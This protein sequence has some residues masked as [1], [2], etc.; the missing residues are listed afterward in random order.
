MIKKQQKM[1][2]KKIYKNYQYKKKAKNNLK[3]K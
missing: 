3:I 2:N 1:N